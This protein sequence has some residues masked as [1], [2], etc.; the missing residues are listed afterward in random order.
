MQDAETA[1]PGRHHIRYA[2]LPHAGPLDSRTVRTARNFNHPLKLS[3]HG[4]P[5]VRMASSHLLSTAIKLEGS[6]ALILD[7]IKRGEDDEDVSRG[8]LPKRKGRSIIVRIYESLGGKARGAIRSSLDVKK[9][10]KT[11]LLEDDGE[12]MVM[13]EDGKV[14]IELRAYEVVTFRLQL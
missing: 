14:G 10:W 8:E 4:S 6:T 2:I 7:C 9:V 12:E 1:S 13:T 5:A 11:N 3:S